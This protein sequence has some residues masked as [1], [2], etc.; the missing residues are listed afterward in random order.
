MGLAGVTFVEEEEDD[1]DDDEFKAG[2][3]L[4]DIS[5]RLHPQPLS[6]VDLAPIP[7]NEGAGR[8]EI[9]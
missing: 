2:Q 3:T 7:P 1:D 8:N 6:G 9:P 5:V 4:V